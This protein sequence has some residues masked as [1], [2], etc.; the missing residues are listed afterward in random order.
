MMV[1]VAGVLGRA[2]FCREKAGF[3]GKGPPYSTRKVI[4]T[5]FKGLGVTGADL[6]T[7]LIEMVERHRSGKRV[8]FYKRGIPPAL[9]RVGIAHGLHHFLS[10]LKHA[11]GLSEC[12]TRL[13]WLEKSAQLSQDPIEVACD[14]FAGELLV[15]FDVLDDL[16]PRS[17]FPKDRVKDHIFRDEVDHLSSKF[18]VPVG[19]MRWRL[20]DLLHL[21]RTHFFIA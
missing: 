6:P 3:A 10:D 1:D 4:E 5:C 17:L 12:N 13:R 21:R 7:G 8:L 20:F 14:L 2:R 11:P 16:A 18:N 15:P 9:Q 19:F